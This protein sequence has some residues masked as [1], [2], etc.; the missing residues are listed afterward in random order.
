MS[1]DVAKAFHGAIIEIGAG[2][3]LAPV[4]PEERAWNNACERA[5]SI[6]EKY[7]NGEG[8]FQMT[9]KLGKRFKEDAGEER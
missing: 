7:K 5:I 6:C 8:L 9:T 2:K 4:K 1:D 3:V